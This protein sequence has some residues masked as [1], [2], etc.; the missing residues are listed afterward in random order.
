M[1]STYKE[2][3][4]TPLQIWINTLKAA[5]GL[6]LYGIG[7]YLTIQANIGVA[8]WDCLFLGICNYTVLSY[9]F[10][11]ICIK[12]IIILIDWFIGERI[13][14]G[15][16]VDA[17][18]VGVTVDVCNLLNILPAQSSMVVGILLMFAGLVI[19]GI[20]QYIYMQSA[21]CCGPVDALFVGLSKKLP[22]VPIGI[23]GV[24][25]LSGV[26][27]IGFLL[28]GPIGIGTVIGALC[29]TPT[30]QLVFQILKFVPEDVVHQ[31]FAAS[32]HVIF[33]INKR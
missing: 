30:M 18:V 11:T 4:L 31:D 16:V 13:G 15:T 12:L 1:K 14:I 10:I 22:R 32:F 24:V 7:V 21:L 29:M 28:G 26:V 2:K 9:G 20:G 3:N 27:I 5:A 8:P 19:N 33:R 23:I 25:I 17:V 6:S